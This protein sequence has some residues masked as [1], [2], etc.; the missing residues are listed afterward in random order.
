[1][2]TLYAKCDYMDRENKRAKAGI[3]H[4]LS[5]CATLDIYC[6]VENG[7]WGIWYDAKGVKYLVD[8]LDLINSIFMDD[9]YWILQEYNSENK[10]VVDIQR[11]SY[12]YAWRVG[13][14]VFDDGKPLYFNF[15]EYVNKIR[16]CIKTLYAAWLSGESVVYSS[17]HD[18][19]CEAIG[20]GLEQ[21]NVVATMPSYYRFMANKVKEEA[22]VFKIEKECY[23]EH[24]TIGIG[25]RI[26]TT[27]LTHW[28]NSF[29]R[30]RYQFESFVHN[31]EAKIELFFDT[32]ETALI[33]KHISVLDQIDGSEGGY[34]FKYRDYALVEIH[35]N[36]FVHGP[37]LKGYCDLKQTIK[38]FYEGLLTL[39]LNHP[40]DS[41]D[42]DD[43]DVPCQLEAYNMFKSPIIERYISDIKED[44]QKAELRQIHV[45]R[46][47]I[48]IPDYDE[49]IIDS[50]G[51]NVDSEGG[52]FDELYD[53]ENNP[54]RMP[55]LVGWQKEIFNVVV[56]GAVGREV[57]FDWDDYHKRGLELARK[58]RTRLSSDFDLWYIAPVEDKSG[59][60]AKPILIYEKPNDEEE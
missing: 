13:G 45:K 30:I 60:I 41:D 56:D 50:E 53:K 39:A 22:F 51:V 29:D 20:I 27:W 35:P 34:F 38:T 44:S 55:E 10:Y 5:A 6:G 12:C 36:E 18:F 58:L 49:V 52:Y 48:V 3:M 4:A 37:I 1:M 28:D 59:L 23:N 21:L 33:I 25:N 14:G 26:Y 11:D 19:D 40:I 54:I 7:M 31:C 17:K 32:S 8:A 9:K 47:L 15:E 2:Q 57:S 42:P 16:E 46:I 24:Y 43:S